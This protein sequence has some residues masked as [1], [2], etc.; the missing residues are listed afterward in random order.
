MEVAQTTDNVKQ[1]AVVGGNGHKGRRPRDLVTPSSVA[2][3]GNPI[4]PESPILKTLQQRT[5]YLARCDIAPATARCCQTLANSYAELLS[6]GTCR[7]RQEELEVTFYP[8]FEKLSTCASPWAGPTRAKS[9]AGSRRPVSRSFHQHLSVISI[10]IHMLPAIRH[11]YELAFELSFWLLTKTAL[12]GTKNPNSTG[13]ILERLHSGPT[14]EP[15]LMY[16]PRR[17]VERERIRKKGRRHPRGDA[18]AG[19]ATAHASN[20]QHR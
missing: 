1:W 9:L 17:L 8:A 18:A 4:I 2:T 14:G 20:A 3:Q 19:A 6:A 13:S 7:F 12:T 5:H 10:K 15:D 16:A 11:A